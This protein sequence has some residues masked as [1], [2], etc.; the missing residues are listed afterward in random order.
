MFGH[1]ATGL[2]AGRSISQ[3]AKTKCPGSVTASRH[4]P[5]HCSLVGFGEAVLQ[6]GAGAAAN[7]RAVEAD[8]AAAAAL[9]ALRQAVAA[10]L[11]HRTAGLVAARAADAAAVLREFALANSNGEVALAAGDAVAAADAAAQTIGQH[12][13]EVLQ[14]A[15]RDFI[16][17]TAMDL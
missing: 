12:A 10:G 9:A 1:R 4:T 8:V 16:I 13:A 15:A 6:L 14:R 5:G 11:N 2:H 3:M 7:R 17:A